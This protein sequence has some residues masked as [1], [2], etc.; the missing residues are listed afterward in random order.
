MNFDIGIK[1][2]DNANFVNSSNPWSI[3]GG[4]YNN[5]TNTGVFNFNRN[6]GEANINNSWR[7]AQ[8]SKLFI[9]NILFKD[10]IGFI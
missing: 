8:S 5:T 10:N 6:T 2:N 3:R 9:P 4:N 1:P 7:L